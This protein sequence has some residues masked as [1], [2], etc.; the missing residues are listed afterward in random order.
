MNLCPLDKKYFCIWLFIQ[1]VAFFSYRC[2]F[3]HYYIQKTIDFCTSLIY[4][5]CGFPLREIAHN[6]NNKRRKTES[7]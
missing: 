2:S 1:N 7:K 6:K 4:N 3:F 5:I